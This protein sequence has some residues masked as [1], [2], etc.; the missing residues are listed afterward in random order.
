MSDRSTKVR[1]V[2]ATPAIRG[3]KMALKKLGPGAVRIV[4]PVH[5]L[6]EDINTVAKTELAKLKS[7]QAATPEGS[8]TPGLAKQL[9][10]LSSA[11]ER[12]YDLDMKVQERMR[13]ELQDAADDELEARAAALLPS[14]PDDPGAA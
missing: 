11:V 6:L 12:A 9:D 2:H 7:R 3:P 14:P 8:A 10:L 4:P 1:G 5:A 13:D